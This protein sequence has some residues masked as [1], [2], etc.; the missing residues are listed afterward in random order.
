MRV[1]A[2]RRGCAE[3]AV[4][5]IIDG[6]FIRIRISDESTGHGGRSYFA[7]SVLFFAGT[8]AYEALRRMIF[9]QILCGGQQEMVSRI[10][11][12]PEG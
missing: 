2:R 1:N 7:N 5:F 12:L 6:I 4:D 8:Q 3:N 11:V 9:R 10:A